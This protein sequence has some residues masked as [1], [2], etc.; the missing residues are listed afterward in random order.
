VILAAMALGLAGGLF[1]YGFMGGMARSMVEAG[2][3]R[4]LAHIQIHLPRFKLDRQINDVI[5]DVVG[6]VSHL[7]TLPGVTGV[8]ARAVIQGMALSAKANA[9]V[10]VCG[11]DPTAEERTTRIAGAVAEGVFLPAEDRDGIVIGRRLAEKLGLRLGAKMVVSFAA[12]DGAIQ[13]AAFRVKGIFVTASS[14]FDRGT[15]FVRRSDVERLTGGGVL[16]HEIAVRMRDGA[17]VEGLRAALRERYPHLAVDAWG[18]LAPDLRLAAET[19]DVTMLFFLGIILLALLFGITNTVLMSVL[20]RTRELGVLMAIGM[21]RKRVFTLIVL[22]TL[23]LSLTGGLVGMLLGGTL[24]AVT[25]GT[26]I[27]LSLFAEGLSSYGIGSVV[28]P[29]L[30]LPVCAE[31]GAL[32]VGTALAASLYPALKAI[33]MKPVEAT[34]TQA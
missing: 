13:E 10:T 11:I 14:A 2:I 29:V 33:R 5:P 6:I 23:F 30:P 20:D 1:A 28:H 25:S 18:D 16:V 31:V 3:D 22:E 26:G 32:T 19:T 24:V 8:S 9:A 27:S 12:R 34:R 21:N 7:E 4:S 17:L 15:V